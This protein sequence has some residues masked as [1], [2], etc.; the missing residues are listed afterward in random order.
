MPRHRPKAVPAGEP[1]LPHENVLLVDSR[2]KGGAGDELD[3]LD[4][5]SA[6]A[7]ASRPTIP[8]L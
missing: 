4:F 2:F 5:R 1:R 6:R 3:D 8:L 7:Q